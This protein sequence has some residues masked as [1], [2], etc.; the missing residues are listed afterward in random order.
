T[1]DERA[2]EISEVAAHTALVDDARQATG[3][4]QHAKQRR[5]RQADGRIAIVDE[6]NVVARERQLVAAAGAN[7]VERREK[8]QSRL[9]AGV[10][11]GE[12]RLVGVFAEVDLPAVARLAQHHD[13]RAGA[14][15]AILEAGDY[16]RVNF[17]MLEADALHGVG[18]L[19]VDAEIVGV[20]L[21]TV[22]G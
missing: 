1:L 7:A 15:H 11:E 18:E 3:A 4:G 10:F 20:E 19:D 2:E 22:L 5:L 12:P 16:D 9:R 6:K 14:E 17:R 13:V 8:T 21:Q